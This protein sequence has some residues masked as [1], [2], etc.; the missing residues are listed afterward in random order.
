VALV[1]DPDFASPGVGNGTAAYEAD[2][3]GS[4]WTFSGSAGVTGNGRAFTSGNRPAP[5]GTQVAFLQGRSQISQTIQLAAG[6]YAVSF[7]AAQ[8]GNYE[9]S[10]Q[11]IELLF[12]GTIV[13]KFTPN[14]TAY[15]KSPMISIA[16]TTSG[17]HIVEFVR[18]NP[19]DG[20]SVDVAGPAS[21][22]LAVSAKAPS[23]AAIG[24]TPVIE[25]A[26]VL[27]SSSS[28]SPVS[29]SKPSSKST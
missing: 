1:P 24:S 17:A 19:N 29:A 8:R 13:A 4:P 5:V 11:T 9:A 15:A 7:T 16:V 3:P 14:G 10:S 6:L 20:S 23:A 18:L 12:D 2:P 26:N 27:N 28:V 21:G 25:P 22:D